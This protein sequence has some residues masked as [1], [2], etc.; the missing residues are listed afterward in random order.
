ML[1]VY[2]QKGGYTKRKAVV[3]FV[4][5]KIIKSQL[6]KKLYDPNKLNYKIV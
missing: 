4:G 5:K 2:Q 6:N 3:K 1:K